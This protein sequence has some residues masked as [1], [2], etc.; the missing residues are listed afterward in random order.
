MFCQSTRYLRAIRAGTGAYVHAPFPHV[1]GFVGP[2]PDDV[3]C[4]PALMVAYPSGTGFDT[5]AHTHTHTQR[6]TDRQTNTTTRRTL[7]RVCAVFS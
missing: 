6:H 5:Q 1:L 3:P 4:P 2:G 7:R